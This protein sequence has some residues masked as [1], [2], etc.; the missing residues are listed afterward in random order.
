MPL[1]HIISTASG[2]ELQGPN[3]FTEELEQQCKQV[4]RQSATDSQMDT[5]EDR[6]QGAHP[7]SPI[8]SDIAATGPSNWAS[9]CAELAAS[10]V[11]EGGDDDV[12]SES[13]CARQH[14]L[15]LKAKRALWESTLPPATENHPGEIDPGYRY[16]WVEQ[17]QTNA[18]HG[19]GVL[20]T[21]PVRRRR[22]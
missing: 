15:H 10:A 12:D 16:L 19:G 22:K 20:T 13:E 6:D 4:P 8:K 9:K 1:S 3:Y 2:P 18:P 11:S 21:P 17:G 14:Q 5:S 7:L